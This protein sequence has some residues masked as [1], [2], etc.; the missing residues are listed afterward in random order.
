MTAVKIAWLELGNTHVKYLS[1][2]QST[3]PEMDIDAQV[4]LYG[5]DQAHKILPKLQQIST[6]WLSH[7]L[8][9]TTAQAWLK[10]WS[11]QRHQR[12][13]LRI[14]NQW[15]QAFGLPVA[16][17]NTQEYG[18]DRWLSSY[19]CVD[20]RS[21]VVIDCGT[22]I[23]VDVWQQGRVHQGGWIFASAKQYCASF[24]ALNLMAQP[25]EDYALA[26]S[27]QAAIANGYNQLVQHWLVQLH[28]D[29]KRVIGFTPER[30][31]TTGN[32]WQVTACKGINRFEKHSNLA[33]KGL[34]KLSRSLSSA[35]N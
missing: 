5:Y 17:A 34:V 19:A 14:V 21:T 27:T 7:A 13:Q 20:E 28:N 33:L 31:V 18:I 3:L 12:R 26:T 23:S 29:A 2:S 11:I 15:Q 1:S 24:T 32:G 10:Q 35:Y 22:A 4:R 8:Q 25:N 16:Y 6:I 9:N 30:I